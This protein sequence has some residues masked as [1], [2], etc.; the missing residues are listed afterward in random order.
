MGNV[1]GIT[2][3]FFTS[4]APAAVQMVD[5]ELAALR[6]EAGLRQLRLL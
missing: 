3:P 6:L 4:L 1:A 2:F 5:L